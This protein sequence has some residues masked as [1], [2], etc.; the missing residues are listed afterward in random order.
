MTIFCL[1]TIW[2]WWHLVLYFFRG[3]NFC[4]KILGMT[5]HKMHQHYLEGNFF[6][7]QLSPLLLNLCRHRIFQT[8]KKSY[9]STNVWIR[10]SAW[11][12]N[13]KNPWLRIIAFIIWPW[14]AIGLYR[15]SRCL[16]FKRSRS[17]RLR[18]GK[19]RPSRRRTLGKAVR[20]NP[21]S[22]ES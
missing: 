21:I 22:Q 19:T 12:A 11:P 9:W 15:V 14:L 7:F 10:E 6:R 13:K 18:H 5:H 17:R 8:R 2:I 3:S 20:S 4:K 16:S 1:E